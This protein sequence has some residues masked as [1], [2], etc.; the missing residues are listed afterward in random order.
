MVCATVRPARSPRLPRPLAALLALGLLAIGSVNGAEPR[1]ALAVVPEPIVLQPV[2]G[3]LRAPAP[4]AAPAAAAVA[5][6]F[7]SPLRARFRLSSAFGLRVHPLRRHRHLH[8]GADLAA[9]RGTPV[10]A[11]ADGIVSSVRSTPGGYGRLIVVDHG[12]GYSSWYAHLDAFE[13]GV[14]PGQALARGA[15]LGTVGASGSATGPHLHLELR[16]D[17]VPV[18][19]M[20]LLL[21]PAGPAPA[22]PGVANAWRQHA[23]PP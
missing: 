21:A 13:P 5:T 2:A 10:H 7:D 8:S 17:A 4:P 9:P 1:R 11:V 3:L 19:P 20:A 18:D 12:N 6:R 16:R 15:R 14:R 22:T 23:S